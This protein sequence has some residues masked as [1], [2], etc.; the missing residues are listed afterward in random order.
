MTSSCASTA[1]VCRAAIILLVPPHPRQTHMVISPPSAFLDT[2][3]IGTPRGDRPPPGCTCLPIHALRARVHRAEIYVLLCQRRLNL[4]PF[5]MGG[6]FQASPTLLRV[7]PTC[8]V[9]DTGAL[10]SQA[11]VS[12]SRSRLVV[13]G[14]T[15]TT[16]HESFLPQ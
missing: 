10:S 16:T 9:S 14:L 1:T 4:H 8:R 2:S 6:I 5:S 11:S 7:S 12:S 3:T 13:A 15:A